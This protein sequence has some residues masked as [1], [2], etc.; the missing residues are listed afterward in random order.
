MAN[1][2]IIESANEISLKGMLTFKSVTTIKQAIV[3]WLEKREGVT[4][5]LSG[6]RYSDSSGLALLM[7][8]LRYAKQQNK[9][10]NFVDMPEQMRAIAQ[11]TDLSNILFLGDSSG[12]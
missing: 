10:L 1:I 6:V 5:G 12:K 8:W 2:E 7:E 3:R 11:V 9:T 4:I